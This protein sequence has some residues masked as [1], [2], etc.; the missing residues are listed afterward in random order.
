MHEF[1]WQLFRILSSIAY[2]VCP[3]PERSVVSAAYK[4]E[5]ARM[6]D[7]MERLAAARPQDKDVGH[8]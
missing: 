4:Y 7:V 6:R 1:R 3:E 2:W 5:T 8:G